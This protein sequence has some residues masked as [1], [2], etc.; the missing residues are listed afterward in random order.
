MA[1]QSTTYDYMNDSHQS[2]RCSIEGWREDRRSAKL[3]LSKVVNGLPV[4]TPGLDP[5]SIPTSTALDA[6]NKCMD[7]AI[8]IC[9]GN[10]PVSICAVQDI[11][12]AFVGRIPRDHCLRS[13]TV[14][15]TVVLPN[16]ANERSWI[17]SDVWPASFLQKPTIYENKIIQPGDLSRMHMVAFLTDPLR[18]IRR[19]GGDGKAKHVDLVFTGRTGEVWKEIPVVVKDLVCGE[20]DVKDF[21]VFRRYFDGVRHMTKSVQ[22]AIKNLNK[23]R[24]KD[25]SGGLVQNPPESLTSTPA[26]A[27]VQEVIDLTAEAP[28]GPVGLPELRAAT[29][30]L[31]MTRI[32][33]SFKDLRAGYH[34]LLELADDLFVAASRLPI[35]EHL[36][37]VLKILQQDREYAASI[38]PKKV[39]VSHYGYNESDEKLAEYRSDPDGY[40]LRKA[41]LRSKRKKARGQDA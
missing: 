23:L 34:G 22:C 28:Q 38:F 41:K 40:I 21:E 20:S 31:A 19:F 35:N 2:Y 33:G 15:I 3:W 30:A 18:K 17:V 39:D 32:R 4:D 8:D 26:P 6:L 24:D 1:S 36:A 10:D 16:D 9:C 11:I 37:C 27:R 13:L 29:R 5:K 25:M 7:L 14:T 12:F